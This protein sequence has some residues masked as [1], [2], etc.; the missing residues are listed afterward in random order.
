[1]WRIKVEL[2]LDDHRK[3]KKVSY[4]NKSSGRNKLM[5]LNNGR[6]LEHSLSVSQTQA[7]TLDKFLDED[8]DAP[9]ELGY[10]G[11]PL[12]LA[13]VLSITPIALLHLELLLYVLCSP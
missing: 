12:H 11:G 2:N 6:W 5:G 3:P 7:R 4:L 10:K 8:T 9:A 13:W 1:M